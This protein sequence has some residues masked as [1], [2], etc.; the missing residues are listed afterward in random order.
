M[1]FCQKCGAENADDATFCNK[2]GAA[3]KAET[4]NDVVL[5]E[6]A[7]ARKETNDARKRA[8]LVAIIVILSA[9]TFVGY[10]DFG[11][12]AKLS[13]TVHSLHVT[14]T[15]DVQITVDGNVVYTFHDL[16]PDHYMWNEKYITVYFSGFAQSK[17][18]T[19]KAISTG[20]GLGSTD[21]TKELI[22]EN[23]QK[24]NID[25]YL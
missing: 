14:E 4:N 10:S 1:M 9:V 13:V 12:S 16:E 11:H 20:G 15:I 21:A 23:D 6:I 22:I 19:V 25:F 17:L 7:Q 8:I 18:I 2:C 3:M 5:H 24:Y